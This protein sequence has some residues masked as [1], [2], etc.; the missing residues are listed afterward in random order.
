MLEAV[1]LQHYLDAEVNYQRS[2]PTPVFVS[3]IVARRRPCRNQ[4][5]SWR[6]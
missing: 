2:N 1:P 3:A 5:L 4:E 6:N